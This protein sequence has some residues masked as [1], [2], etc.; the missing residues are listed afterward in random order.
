[1]SGCKDD[2]VTKMA[3]CKVERKETLKKEV[4][5]TCIVHVLTV[6]QTSCIKYSSENAIE[7]KGG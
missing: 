6:S 3:S 2:S 4:V 1:M 7:G 5:Y